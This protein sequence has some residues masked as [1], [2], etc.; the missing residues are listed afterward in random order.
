MTSAKFTPVNQG[1][2]FPIELLCHTS[3]C[4]G[5]SGVDFEDVTDFENNTGLDTRNDL[6]LP[7][8]SEPEI[9]RHFTRLS[10]KNYSIDSGFYPLGSCTMKYNP[11]LNEKTARFPGFADIHPN[12]LDSSVQGA[13]E[14]MHEL[15]DWLAKLSGLDA[16]SLNPAA[17]AHGEYSGLKVIK[18]AHLKK[19]GT[20]RK[21][22]LIPESAHGTNPATA[23]ALGYK[24]INVKTDSDGCSLISHLEEQIKEYGEEIAAIMLT[25][26]NTAGKFEKDV[27]KIADLVHSVGAYFYCDGA[28][29]NAIV[30]N[31]KPGDFGVDV[32][33]FNLHK[34]FSTPHG[35]G[36]PGCGPIAVQANLKQFLPTP[37]A[38]KNTDSSFSMIHHS[39]ESIGQIKGFYGQFTL[40][41]RALTYM[42]S[43][44]QD[45][46]KQV[47]Y[48]AVLS[49]NYIL[50]K[51]KDHYHVPFTGR[52]MH[53]CLLTDKTQKSK[54]VTTLDIAKALIEYGMHPMTMYFPLVV[55]G[56]MLIEPTETESK[57]TIDYF[58][59][60]MIYIAQKTEKG[61]GEKFTEYPTTTEYARLDETL[62][63][64]N[65]IL[66]WFQLKD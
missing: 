35:G 22:V 46:L 54:G 45:G 36:G 39:A 51:L 31:I 30:G 13:L 52:C 59:N 56:A 19:E 48:D 2:N 44:G 34:T 7:C 62:A 5:I 65:P 47:S 25:N 40:M 41:V 21:Y 12:Q 17:G 15:Q 8:H 11:R 33:H 4:S 66:T 49:A 26:P 9:V 16:V 14:L 42:M 61:D 55:S 64:R 29:F 28:N 38:K 1:L 6:N 50:D 24:I 63:A 20:P 3:G 27:V 60:T 37:F 18:Y 57:A 58:I 43:L 23:V 53:E 10:Q 32:M